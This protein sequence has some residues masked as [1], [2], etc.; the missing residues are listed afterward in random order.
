MENL[1][2]I[3][4][5]NQKLAWQII[6]DLDIIN[7]WK[8]SGARINLVG[9]LKM[10]LMMK[11]RDIDFHIYTKN[12]SMAKARKV[13]DRLSENPRILSITTKDLTDTEEACIECHTIYTDTANNNWQ[14]DMIYIEEGSKYD[15]YFE[16]IAERVK[17]VLTPEIK[18]TILRLK[19]ET[20]DDIK[21]P[22]I[23]YYKAV[24]KDKITTLP[25]LIRLHNTD[26][27]SES[28]IEWQP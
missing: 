14:I 10:G 26:Y 6:H 11:H 18:E 8:S 3:S 24:I 16:K 12:I 15:G 13:L 25:E 22:G 1:F 9:S 2:E 7:L 21:I 17:K 23:E 28:I 20:P 19:Y 5:R 27:N 4:E